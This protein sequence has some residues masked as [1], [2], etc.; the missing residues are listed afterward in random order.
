MPTDKN[1]IVTK[2]LD[3]QTENPTSIE[4]FQAWD[5]KDVPSEKQV[6]QAAKAIGEL[7]SSLCTGGWKLARGDLL[8]AG[9]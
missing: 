7:Q 8:C 2:P 3:V 6:A 5:E 4:Q 9:V 1:L